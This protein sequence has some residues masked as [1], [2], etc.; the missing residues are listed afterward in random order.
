MRI[1][2]TRPNWNK[3][4]TR[5][6]IPRP[7]RWNTSLFFYWIK[8]ILKEPFTRENIFQS[9][10]NFPKHKIFLCYLFFCEGGARIPFPHTDYWMTSSIWIKLKIEK[11]K[12]QNFR[13]F[14]IFCLWFFNMFFLNLD[15]YFWFIFYFL[16]NYFITYK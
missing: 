4:N 14:F 10:R 5:V 1:K 15:I 13:L 9:L 2:I 8:T 6:K 7:N 12:L 16:I 3:K 11:H